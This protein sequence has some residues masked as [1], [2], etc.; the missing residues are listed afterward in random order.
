MVSSHA[1][2]AA[3]LFL[4]DML[5]CPSAD[6]LALFCASGDRLTQGVFTF[7]WPCRKMK[8]TVFLREKLSLHG[9]L[10]ADFATMSM[11]A[12]VTERTTPN[13]DSLEGPC[14]GKFDDTKKRHHRVD[15]AR[16]IFMTF[17]ILQI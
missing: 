15:L 2:E 7:L 4:A 8:M 17:D 6:I 5:G 1:C 13:R 16:S 9:G 12:E 10:C 11:V 3:N 14:M